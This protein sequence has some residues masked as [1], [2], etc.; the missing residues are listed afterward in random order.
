[1]KHISLTL[2][3]FFCFISCKKKETLTPEELIIGKWSIFSITRSDMTTPTCELDNR[4]EFKKGGVFVDSQGSNKCYSFF[5]SDVPGLWDM[6]DDY[7]KLTIAPSQTDVT[8]TPIVYDIL[9]LTSNQMT[10]KTDT[11]GGFPYIP[12]IQRNIVLRK[13]Q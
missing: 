2:I 6:N 9:E 3:L 13:I 1:M 5:V 7:K 10:I 12:N 11:V 8:N 4:Y